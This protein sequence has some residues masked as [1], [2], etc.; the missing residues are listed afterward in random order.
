[1]ELVDA[2]LAPD[3]RFRHIAE[4]VGLGHI[5]RGYDNVSDDHWVINCIV[6]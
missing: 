5:Y 2:L 1:M 3:A 6:S 4:D